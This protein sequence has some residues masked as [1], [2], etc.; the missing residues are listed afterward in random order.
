MTTEVVEVSNPVTGRTWIDR[1]LGAG[2]QATSRYDKE[3]LGDLYQW[4][5]EADGH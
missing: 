5:R 3:A 4:G 2:R 1:N